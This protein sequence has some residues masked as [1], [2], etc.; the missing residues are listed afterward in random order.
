MAGREALGTVGGGA[1]EY[2]GGGGSREDVGGGGREDVTWVRAAQSGPPLFFQVRGGG[3]GRAGGE[4]LAAVA[5]VVAGLLAA[6]GATLQCAWYPT[7]PA[8]PL[9]L[10]C[11]F[12]PAHPLRRS[13][14]VRSSRVSRLRGAAVSNTLS[15]V[16]VGWGLCCCG[17][18]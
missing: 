15:A 13:A 2:L 18:C 14:W 6:A 17:C 7:R 5:A 1:M 11:P 3:G 4:N 9:I 12:A 16:W 10:R 8:C